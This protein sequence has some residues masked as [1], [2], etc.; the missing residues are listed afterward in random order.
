MD[1]MCGMDRCIICGD[2][3]RGSVRTVVGWCICSEH[4]QW[5][6]ESKY[7]GYCHACAGPLLQGDTC[8]MSKWGGRWIVVHPRSVCRSLETIYAEVRQRYA[9]YFDQLGRRYQAD[10]DREVGAENASGI[11]DAHRVLHVLPS[12][13]YEVVKASYRAL[14]LKHHPDTGGSV[15]AMIRINAAF[16]KVGRR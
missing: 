15:E 8:L 13:P 1:G 5:I 14:S 9:A 2:Q 10:W 4:R 11:T 6:K 7:D 3:P 12:A 16:A